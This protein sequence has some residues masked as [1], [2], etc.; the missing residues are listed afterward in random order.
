MVVALYTSFGVC[1][2]FEASLLLFIFLG[3]ARR[4]ITGDWE[5]IG[6][7]AMDRRRRRREA[8]DDSCRRCHPK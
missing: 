8:Y 3:H 6:R 1:E 7:L 4:Q 5:E 2:R